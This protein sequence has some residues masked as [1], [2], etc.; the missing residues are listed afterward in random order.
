MQYFMIKWSADNKPR[1]DGSI[2][3]GKELYTKREIEKYKTPNSFYEPFEISRRKT[4]WF[5]GARFA[6]G[7]GQMD[8]LQRKGA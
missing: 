4:Y 5:F 8:D 2:Y 3:V 7:H 6:I 1:S